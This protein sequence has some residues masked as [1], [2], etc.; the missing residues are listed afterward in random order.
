MTWKV[1][2]DLRPIQE[3]LEEA[4][5]FNSQLN[6]DIVNDAVQVKWGRSLSQPMWSVIGPVAYWPDGFAERL[7]EFLVSGPALGS[8][9]WVTSE[10]RMHLLRSR[11]FVV[12]LKRELQEFATALDAFFAKEG[13]S[14]FVETGKITA[15]VVSIEPGFDDE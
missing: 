12:G 10:E 3:R 9:L 4:G 14:R 2:L 5:Y 8:L 11:T 7:A 13:V 15:T 6:L 1:E